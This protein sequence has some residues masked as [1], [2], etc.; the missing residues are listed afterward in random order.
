MTVYFVA[1]EA[2]PFVKT[3]G[4]ADVAGSLPRY[5]QKSGVN[6]SVILPCYAQIDQK[7]FELDNTGLEVAVRPGDPET[8]FRVLSCRYREIRFYFLHNESLFFREEIYG[9]YADNGLRFGLFSHA[10]IMLAEKIGKPDI[11]HLNDWHTALIPYLLI[12][13]Y[14]H[15]SKT[16]LTI[17]NLGYQGVFSKKIVDE[18]G[19]LWEDFTL[20]CMEFYGRINFLKTGIAMADR[21]TTVSPTYAEEM[22]TEALGA[23]LN[24]HIS[25]H[26][27][28]LTGILNGL[29]SEE[30]NPESD[31]HLDS[32]FGLDTYEN[33]KLIKKNI[34][35]ELG[36]KNPEKPLFVFIGRFVSQKG[37]AFITETF[38]LLQQI[39]FNMAI[40]GEGAFRYRDFFAKLLTTYENVY[41]YLGYEESLS[42]KLYAA[43]D[44]LLMPSLYEP[45][46][47]NQIIAMRYGSVPIVRKTGGLNDTVADFEA[48]DQEFSGPRGLGIVFEGLEVDS[49]LVAVMRALM[50]YGMK[51]EFDRVVKFNMTRE[52]SWQDSAKKYISEYNHLKG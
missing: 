17:H 32:H 44:F 18:L 24:G 31:S 7:R 21:I 6:I 28:K 19:L 41:V 48:I 36:L 47:L 45:C 13:K 16:V 51:D 3:G 20:D 50:L 40:I 49:F 43:S 39:G 30:W 27:H 35:L 14:G 12:K 42:R 34:I 25:A 11:W 29:D 2:F 33:K 52:F 9:D 10:A 15:D 46:G 5:L 37:I 1:S 38:K 22:Q 8:C 26:A 4:L 23:N